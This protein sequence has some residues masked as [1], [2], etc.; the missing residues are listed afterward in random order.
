M[1]DGNPNV[2]PNSD[3]IH[4]RLLRVAD[5]AARR[6]ERDVRGAG[7]RGCGTDSYS[8]RAETKRRRGRRCTKSILSVC[9]CLFFQTAMRLLISI[10][11]AGV[12]ADHGHW[13]PDGNRAGYRSNP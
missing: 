2:N 13:G 6:H 10:E 7:R 5:F 11:V 8:F 9:V 4:H 12:T 1:Q 3:R